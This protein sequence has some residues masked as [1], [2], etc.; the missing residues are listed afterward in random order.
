[1]FWKWCVKVIIVFLGLW[2]GLDLACSLGAE[3]FWFQE[4]GYLPNLLVRLITQGMIWVIITG[5]SI[6]YFWGNLSLAKKWQ[7]PQ[8]LKMDPA[9]TRKK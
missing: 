5:T 8:E 3:I 1:M 9:I 2:L 6:I 4:V 7:Y